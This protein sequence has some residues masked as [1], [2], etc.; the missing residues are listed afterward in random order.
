MNASM[1]VSLLGQSAIIREGLRRILLDAG[2]E[3]RQSV[4]SS[5]HLHDEVDDDSLLIIVD[6]GREQ[7]GAE[8]IRALHLRFPNVKLVLLSDSFDL[9]AAA[10][11]FRAG[12]HGYIVK[13]IRCESLIA[14]LK[15]A[16]TGEKIMPSCLA[17][18]LP[19]HGD[20]R[21]SDRQLLENAHLS[22]R[23][24]DILSFLIMGCPNKVISRRLMISEA[25]VKVHVK[26]ILRKLRVHNRTQAAI[27][28]VNGGL[29][30]H[31]V[32]HLVDQNAAGQDGVGRPILFRVA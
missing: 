10:D 16:A 28:G 3:V 24:S 19:W 27:R 2:V 22:G 5:F 6:G 4:E 21:E 15:L 12:A 17:D 14:S 30:R 13:E 1:K 20:D 18:A 11:A 23:E 9:R 25:T 26:A 29:H 31:P 32:G 7:A 8:G